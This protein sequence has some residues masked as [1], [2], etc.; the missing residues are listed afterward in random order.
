MLGL[1][2]R[3]A[4]GLRANGLSPGDGIALLLGV[5]PEAFATILA[6]HAVGARV[7]GVRPGLTEAQVEHLLSLDIALV[8]RD[9]DVAG[10]TKASPEP[11]R[12]TGK[13]A[14]SPGS[15]TPAAA[16]ARP[17]RARRRTPR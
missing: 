17:R 4:T 16:R 1:V 14:T 7:V 13:P 9:S 15:S 8:V 6:A 11:L 3:I 2:A 12:C 5:T 10:L